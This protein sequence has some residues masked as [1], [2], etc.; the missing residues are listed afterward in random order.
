LCSNSHHIFTNIAVPTPFESTNFS[1][2]GPKTLSKVCPSVTAMTLRQKA[3]TF[4]TTVLLMNSALSTRK[5]LQTDWE[6]VVSWAVANDAESK[7]LPMPL[8]ILY[9]LLFDFVALGYS[10]SRQKEFINS[11]QDRHKRFSITPPLKYH[12]DYSKIINSILKIKGKTEQLKL[13]VNPMCIKHMLSKSTA[14]FSEE[15]EVLAVALGAACAARPS[16][17]TQIRLCQIRIGADAEIDS[18][19]KYKNSA[20]VHLHTRK[21]DQLRKGHD[22]RI[23]RPIN[24]RF[25]VLNRLEKMW[26][27]KSIAPHPLCQATSDPSQQCVLCPFA[28]SK[29]TTGG[30]LIQGTPQ[31]TDWYSKAVRKHIGSQFPNP[32]R[33][34][35]KS[36]RIGAISNALNYGI[37]EEIIYLQSGHGPSKSGRSYMQLGMLHHLYRMYDSWQL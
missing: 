18:S 29:T 5:K 12:R 10:G 3:E 2:S 28:F 36:T 34:S 35:G 23:G 37:P 4:Q 6:T 8:H 16:E 33:F 17:V 15:Q 19:P 32:S 24:P 25:D 21:Q 13:P 31:S 11:I 14:S 1:L 9:A 27:S 7:I 26:Q 30:K 22:M 20:V